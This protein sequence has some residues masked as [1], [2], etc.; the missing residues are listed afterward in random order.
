M[1]ALEGFILFVAVSLIGW[2]IVE[3]KYRA[4]G[5]E[6]SEE[7]NVANE[8]A[9]ALLKKDGYKESNIRDIL[10]NSSFTGFDAV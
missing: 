9:A 8:K 4:V 1:T 3:L 5:F 2:E 7:E 6:H 10:S